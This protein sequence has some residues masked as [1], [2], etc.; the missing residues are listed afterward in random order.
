M[1]CAAQPDWDPR[2]KH[3]S[4]DANETAGAF[5]AARS[6]R[7]RPESKTTTLMRILTLCYEFPGA[8]PPVLSV[9]LRGFAFVRDTFAT[10]R[11]IDLHLAAYG[12]TIAR[13]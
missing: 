1:P 12:E 11:A 13:G 6:I 7:L 3:A 9:D 8:P 2:V 4:S 10:D 5:A